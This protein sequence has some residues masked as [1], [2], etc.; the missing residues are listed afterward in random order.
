MKELICVCL[1]VLLL[2]GLCGC[3]QGEAEEP[4]IQS[5]TIDTTLQ[6]EPEEFEYAVTQRI[7][8][9]LPEFTFTVRGYDDGE[10]AG[11]SLIEIVGDGFSQR[12]DTDFELESWALERLAL[13]F[14]DFTN[15]GFL[16]LRLQAI[17]NANGPAQFWLWDKDENKFI[18]N[19][20]L[21]EL[22]EGRYALSVDEDGRVFSA[23]QKWEG[24]YY[25]FRNDEFVLVESYEWGH[26]SIDG[27]TYWFE[28]TY[29]LID[30]IME[31]VS[32]TKEE[33]D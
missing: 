19:K 7:H 30:G 33:M 16:D 13:T 9:S 23:P 18:E 1:A 6:T 24:Y 29:Q 3:G 32:Y 14:E 20:Q 25:E 5:T 2:A 22:N 15:D 4:S 31:L 12:L 28:R 21:Q 8:E 26:E 10:I 27:K 11:V 17:Y